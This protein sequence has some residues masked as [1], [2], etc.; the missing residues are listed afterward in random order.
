MAV[1]LRS[2][3]DNH[4]S[5]L[6]RR[7][8]AGGAAGQTQLLSGDGDAVPDLCHGGQNGLLPLLGGQ[9]GQTALTGKFDV[10]GQAVGQ[11]A[12]LPGEDGVRAGNGLGVDVAAEA[13]L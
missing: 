6:P 2:S 8:K 1:A 13:A 4:L 9:Q 11:Q 12:Q 10:H 3:A 5:G 7:C